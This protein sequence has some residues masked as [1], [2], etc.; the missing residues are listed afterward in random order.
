[1]LVNIIGIKNTNFNFKNTFSFSIKYIVINSSSKSK[2][3]Y[4]IIFPLSFLNIYS[5]F[6][7]FIIKYSIKS[8]L[9]TIDSQ[10]CLHCFNYF[11][12]T[13]SVFNIVL[14]IRHILFRFTNPNLFLTLLRVP[15]HVDIII[16]P[17]FLF[18]SYSQI[19]F[20]PF[21]EI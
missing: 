4:I 14:K 13:S 16:I 19:L 20:L 2:S 1:V 5:I 7:S 12:L 10:P 17:N 11:P 18:Y 8:Y 6:Y 3:I 15:A 21:L 9:V